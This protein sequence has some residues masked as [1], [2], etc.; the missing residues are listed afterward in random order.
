MLFQVRPY[1]AKIPRPLQK[2]PKIYFYDNADVEG[3][4]GVRFENLVATHLLKA[5]QFAQDYSGHVF[6]LHYLRDKE[7]REVDFL[8]TKNRRPIQLI[9]AKWADTTPS[10]SLTYYAEKID[11]PEA[12]QVVGKKGARFVR[13]RLRVSD[14][15]AELSNLNCYISDST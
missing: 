1:T 2:P 15:F 8:I 13:G 6:G 14:A 3:D 10:R 11:I 7:K 4:E 12:I 5:L 9:E